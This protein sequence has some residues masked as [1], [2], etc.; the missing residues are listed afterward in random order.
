V[1]LPSQGRVSFVAVICN[2]TVESDET[3]TKPVSCIYSVRFRKHDGPPNS[4]QP[5]QALSF[6]PSC[7]PFHVSHGAAHRVRE[8][9][10]IAADGLSDKALYE[11]RLALVR[12]SRPHPAEPTFQSPGRY[13]LARWCVQ[14]GRPDDVVG[15]AQVEIIRE[16]GRV[17][18]PGRLCHARR[19][20]ARLQAGFRRAIGNLHRQATDQLIQAVLDSKSSAEFF[21]QFTGR[22]GQRNLIK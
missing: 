20:A 11:E 12:G 10:L 22:Q 4:A 21:V 7:L 14:R 1:N 9:G 13:R 17:S 8:C 3:L 6:C 19:S 18:E 16:F 5:K 2:A 15:A